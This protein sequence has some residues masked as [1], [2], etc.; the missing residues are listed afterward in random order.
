MVRRPIREGV[1]TYVMR[2]SNSSRMRR[3][4]TMQSVRQ[5]CLGLIVP[6][7]NSSRRH[8]SR[9]FPS[10]QTLVWVL[11]G[12]FR[13]NIHFASGNPDNLVS[14]GNWYR[15]SGLP[16]SVPSYPAWDADLYKRRKFHRRTIRALVTLVPLLWLGPSTSR[17]KIFRKVTT[18]IE[19]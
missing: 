9:P 16:D 15:S 13:A 10:V 6:R 5:V 19:A 4:T 11:P 1:T 17:Q 3:W 8:R 2:P 14:C 18:S 7:T 12:G